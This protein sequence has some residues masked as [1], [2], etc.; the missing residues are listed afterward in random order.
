MATHETGELADHPR[1]WTADGMDTYDEHGKSRDEEKTIGV[2][3]TQHE[4]EGKKSDAEE[5]RRQKEAELQD[6][7]SLL[8]F[9]QIVFVFMGL[10]C[11]LFCSL[12]DQT[13]CVLP[14]PILRDSSTADIDIL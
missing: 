7:T 5:K 10:T 11:A 2:P 8:P 14:S 13:M 9:K 4:Q 1:D 3:R 12:L 6:Q